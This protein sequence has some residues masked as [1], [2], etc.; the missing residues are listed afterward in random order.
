MRSRRIRQALTPL[1]A[2][3]ALGVLTPAVAATPA[4]AA[5]GGAAVTAAGTLERFT[6]Q[7]VDWRSCGK[8]YPAAA[9]CA[10]LSVPLDYR[11]PGGKTIEIAVSRSK[12]TDPGKRRGALFLNQGG[13]GGTGVDFPYYDILKLPKS[14]KERYDLIGFD[15]R[16][17]GQSTP[18]ACG[19]RPQEREFHLPYKPETFAHDMAVTRT[20]ADRCRAKYGTDLGQFTTRN[21]ARDMD[22]I[23]A[24]LGERKLSY[25]GYSYG[26]YLG[27]VYTQLFPHR[28][29]R[30]ILD[31]AIDPKLTW[32]KDHLLYGSEV[33]KAFDRWARWTAER[34]DTYGLGTTP[35]AVS[36][37]FWRIVAR[38]DRA[39]IVTGGIPLTGDEIR[40]N[41]QPVF[42][43]AAGAAEKV[44]MLKRAAAGKPTEG[45]PG[46]RDLFSDAASSLLLAVHCGDGGWPRDPETYRKDAIRDKARYPLYGDH[47]ANISPCAFWDRPV[48]RPTRVEN[49]VPAMIL[50]NE[51]DPATPLIGARGLREDMR[52]SRLV[53]VDEGEGHGVYA[54]GRNACVDQLTT[55]Y[56][57]HGRLPSADRTCRVETPRQRLDS[58][59]GTPSTLATPGLPFRR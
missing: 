18:I 24:V 41:M 16:G 27:A 25:L 29:D 14:V 32:R 10:T 34:S 56:L 5:S 2:V 15:P 7:R 26:T 44:A 40:R 47:A 20:T 3:S 53:V 42:S 54:T 46:A 31:S 11:A 57:V 52:G 39:P 19:L 35:K 33:E 36:D 49:D 28:S 51:W 30:V 9:R 55:A 12:A 17:V 4:S 6:E 38:A 59:E 8:G 58:N 50:Q 21:T 13:P 37:T 43:S 22:V 48:E 45:L 23:R 1:L